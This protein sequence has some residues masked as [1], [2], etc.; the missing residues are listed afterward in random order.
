MISDK[1]VHEQKLEVSNEELRD[2]MKIEIMRYFGTMNLGDD[3][4][5]IE[6]YIDRMMKD[7]K[8][9]DASYRR[10][11]TDKLFTWLEGQ[12]KAKEK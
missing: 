6:S 1:L 10:L 12:V 9:V 4:S 5:W 8:Q 3:T 7:E 2:Y 11:I